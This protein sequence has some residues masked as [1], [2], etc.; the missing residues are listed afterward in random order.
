MDWLEFHTPPYSGGLLDQP[1]RL[2]KEIRLCLD[3]Y[4]N[5]T[6]WRSA[7]NS[8]NAEAF[9]KFC[10]AHSDLVRFMEYVWSEQDKAREREAETN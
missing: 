7:Q 9:S 8:L 2:M 5:I 1:I 3:T 6:T 10:S 4:Q